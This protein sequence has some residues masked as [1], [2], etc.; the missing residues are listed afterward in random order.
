MTL[1]AVERFKI[2]NGLNAQRT[3]KQLFVVQHLT[4]TLHDSHIAHH[5]TVLRECGLLRKCFDNDF[6]ADARCIA[7]GDGQR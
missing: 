4:R 3:R 6:R 7:H 1:R 5:H 2:Y